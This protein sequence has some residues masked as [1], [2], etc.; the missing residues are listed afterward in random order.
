MGCDVHFYCERFTTN[1]EHNGPKELSEERE[2]KIGKVLGEENLE[3]KWISVD[4]WNNDDGYWSSDQ[5]YRG[6]N[7]YLFAALADVRNDYE[8]EPISEPRGIPEDVSYPI[9]HILKVN[10]GSDA[11]SISYFTLKEL[12]DVDWSKYQVGNRADWLDEFMDTINKMKEIDEDPTK[13]RC[14]FFFDN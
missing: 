5:F 3:P 14:I 2:I 4:N 8:I 10:W 11:H 12:L 9:K 13:V 7:Y 1:Y 6:R